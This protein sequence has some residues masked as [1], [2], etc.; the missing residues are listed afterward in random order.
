MRLR[1][2]QVNTH[3]RPR[4]DIVRGGSLAQVLALSSPLSLSWNRRNVSQYLRVLS[5]L[6]IASPSSPLGHRRTLAEKEEMGSSNDTSKSTTLSSLGDTL[7]LP[8]NGANVNGPLKRGSAAA[9]SAAPSREQTV[10]TST[11]FTLHKPSF[12]LMGCP[13]RLSWLLSII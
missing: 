9:C 1:V 12:P 13:A 6:I 4:R 2:V 8:C 5:T 11:L 10:E 7:W 3:L